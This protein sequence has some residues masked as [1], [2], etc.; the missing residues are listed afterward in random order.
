MLNK[1]D[2]AVIQA[3]AKR[4][5]YQKDIAEELGVHPKTVRRALARG[6]APPR[7]RGGRG[8]KLAPYLGR[9][10]QL[11]KE[12]VNNAVVVMREIQAEGYQGGLTVLREYMAPH[13]QPRRERPTVRFESPPGRQM[14]SD[15]GQVWTQ[16]AGE[17]VKVHVIVN[18]LAFSRR[19]HFWCTDSEDA[20][21]TY[22]GL[23]RSFEYFGGVPQEVLV[24]NQKSAVLVPR[25]QGEAV[26]QERFNDLA[27]HYGFLPRAC[28]PYRARTKGKTERM[29]G[30][31]KH[32]F[33]VRYRDFDS[34]PHLNQL[35]ERW[36]AEETDQRRHGTVD[37]VVAERFAVEMS[38]LAALP[39]VRYDTAYR[40]DRVVSWDG[41]VEVRGRRFSVPGELAGR[42]VKVQ[43]ALD[44]TLK[45][46]AD[47]KVVAEHRLDRTSRAWVTVA[48]HHTGLWKDALGVQQRP[49]A[50]YEEVA[51]WN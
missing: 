49:L 27:G 20:E 40:L 26:F 48:E 12:G 43:L 28:R 16:V 37:Q 23:I 36:L 44:D 34:W 30:Y 1:E 50:D 10:D 4:G 39:V 51:Q 11:I 46:V 19:F 24:D 25:S 18:V 29:V 32:H 8:S 15:W 3:L 14:Q 38:T 13:R 31:T 45:V 9:I 33:F 2:F 42:H 47:D 41:Y 17:R 22:E 6:S 5:V 35:G 21:H 7:E